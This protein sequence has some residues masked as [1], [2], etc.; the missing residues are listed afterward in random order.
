LS[1]WRQRLNWGGGAGQQDLPFAVRKAV[2]LSLVALIALV[3]FLKLYVVTQPSLVNAYLRAGSPVEAVNWIIE[4]Q[5]QGRL[6][7]SYNW[8]GYLIWALP[9]YPVFV[10]GRTDLYGDEI[11]GEWMHIVQAGE[12]WQ[13]RLF[14]WQVNLVLIEPD[15]PLAKALSEAGWKILYQDDMSVIY[16][17]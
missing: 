3:A 17:R 2:N 6:F 13:Q 1:D 9:E 14:D 12:N 10:D 16:G 4:N 5:P 8:G 7:S 11:I 15:R